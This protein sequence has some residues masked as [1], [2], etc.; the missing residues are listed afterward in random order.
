MASLSQVFNHAKLIRVICIDRDRGLFYAAAHGGRTVTH[1]LLGKYKADA[2]IKDAWH[3]APFIAL[4]GLMVLGWERCK[5]ILVGQLF[6]F[7][8]VRS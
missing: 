6:V 5:G 4:N 8:G 1:L 3:L 2:L 7:A